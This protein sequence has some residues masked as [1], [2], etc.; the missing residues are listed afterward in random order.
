[1]GF[2]NASLEYLNYPTQVESKLLQRVGHDKKNN[3]HHTLVVLLG[4][5]QMLQA[6]SCASW[7]NT[8]PGD[9]SLLTV[10]IKVT[11]IVIYVSS[12]C[13]TSKINVLGE[14]LWSF[15]LFGRGPHVPWAH[16]L[17]AR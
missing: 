12:H 8:H 1:M 16:P 4:D 14:A 17:L 13:N 5:L 7:W 2:S 9:Q 11:G 15:G 3:S 10:E 6:D